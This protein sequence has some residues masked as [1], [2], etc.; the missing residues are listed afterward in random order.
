MGEDQILASQKIT[1]EYF[2]SALRG[3][4][5]VLKAFRFYPPTHPAL[6]KAV[7]ETLL[8]FKTLLNGRESIVFSVHK[9]GFLVADTAIG[10]RMPA[11]ENLALQLF[12]R[13]IRTL[14]ILHDLSARDLLTFA[15]CLLQE[16][17]EIQSHGG[18]QQLLCNNA[19]STIWINEIDLSLALARKKTIERAA[20]SCSSDEQPVKESVTSEIGI[21]MPT[22][23]YEEFDLGKILRD[24]E[25][26]NSDQHFQVLSKSIDSLVLLNLNPD[27]GNLVMRTLTVLYHFATS[28]QL[29]PTRRQIA[30]TVLTRLAREEVIEF[31][32]S[33]LCQKEQPPK[34]RARLL[35]LT[36]CFRGKIERY[37]MAQLAEENDAQARKILGTA[38]IRLGS[39]ASP[40]LIE[41][42][43][44]PRWF[45]VRNAVGILGE[46]R[47]Q[48]AT[49]YMVP[50]L[51][52]KDI[53]VRRET[54]RALTKI[55]GHNAENTLLKILKSEDPEMRRQAI[56]SLG[57]LQSETAL[58]ALIDL[59][60]KRDRK[61]LLRKEKIEAVKALGQI[62]SPVAVPKLKALLKRSF[63]WF[64]TKDSELRAEAAL[65][66]GRIGAP[67]ACKLLKKAARDRTAAVAQAARL[68]L[69]RIEKTL[70]HA[71]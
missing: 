45:V 9:E 70:S 5:V 12:S 2:E 16:P 48:K 34:A 19:V 65:A 33:V 7:E 64:S 32:I 14:M 20:Q 36:L 3:L 54:I 1:T 38:L 26:T 57:A 44:D 66:L 59:A 10:N 46:I 43:K 47:D 39:S 28:H 37:L 71:S 42:L 29:S 27:G 18:I 60:V 63:F 31:F 21:E 25:Q 41:Y 53:R 61:G 11:L 55:G 15:H 49:S 58:P 8:K 67:D 51:G 56:L 30:Q 13:H 6:K 24:M 69:N 17:T 23:L 62:G 22:P 35:S 4:D 40:I 68:A 52:H 50:L